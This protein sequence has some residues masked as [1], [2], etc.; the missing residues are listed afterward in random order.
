M[1]SLGSG[2]FVDGDPSDFD[3]DRWRPGTLPKRHPETHLNVLIVGAGLA[4]LMAALECWRKGHTV[5]GILERSH[6]PVY[7]G[8]FS[9]SSKS[10]P[11]CGRCSTELILSLL[12]R[13]RR[14]YHHRA[15]SDRLLQALARYGP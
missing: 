15:V 4:G 13:R 5:V 8:M 12:G 6:G 14:H 9:L 7:A 10:H 11:I 2:Y 1:G 3:P